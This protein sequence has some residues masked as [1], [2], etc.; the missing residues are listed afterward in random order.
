[1]A[2]QKGLAN[3]SLVSFIK[4]PMKVRRVCVRCYGFTQVNGRL[5]VRKA[6]YERGRPRKHAGARAHEQ[7]KKLAGLLR[8]VNP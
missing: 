2:L 5:S 7:A 8:P 1:M 6:L 3:R 4:C